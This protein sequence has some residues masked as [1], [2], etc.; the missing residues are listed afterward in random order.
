MSAMNDARFERWL[1]VQLP[2]LAIAQGGDRSP[3]WHG[4][5]AYAARG[6]H[7]HCW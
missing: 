2:R 1:D 3:L 4:E 7:F 6:V 5:A